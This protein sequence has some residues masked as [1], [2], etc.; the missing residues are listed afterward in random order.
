MKNIVEANKELL[1]GF[2]RLE[3]SS[4][5]DLRQSELSEL[6]IA[7]RV[8]PLEAVSIAWHKGFEAG[9]KYAARHPKSMK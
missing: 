7:S 8:R 3:G 5:Y 1:Q 9:R 4:R 2:D 6:M